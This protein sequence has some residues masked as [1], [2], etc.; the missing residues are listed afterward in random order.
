MNSNIQVVMLKVLYV[1]EGLMEMVVESKYR[2]RGE[3]GK[4]LTQIG[5]NSNP[6]KY[7]PSI[8]D[9]HIPLKSDDH[10]VLL[11][12]PFMK[13]LHPSASKEAW[14]EFSFSGASLTYIPSPSE[15]TPELETTVESSDPEVRHNLFF[16]REEL[17]EDPEDFDWESSSYPSSMHLWWGT[18]IKSS[19]LE[20]LLRCEQIGSSLIEEIPFHALVF[21]T[22]KFHA[23]A[24][25]PYEQSTSSQEGTS[26]T[27]HK[28]HVKKHGKGD[29]LEQANI[30]S[31]YSRS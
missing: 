29:A 12:S 27:A 24:V 14:S 7:L 30:H 16:R 26:H 15:F 10:M 25:A 23:T 6:L 9:V 20:P 18:T 31:A 3:N 17:P 2:A 19:K 1:D 5:R 11:Y 28:G 22:R 21:A 8:A 4:M 13:Y